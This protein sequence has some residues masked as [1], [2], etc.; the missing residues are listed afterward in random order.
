MA[1]RAGVRRVVVVAVVTG[2]A[3]VG[4]HRVRSVQRVIV[5]VDG[6]TGRFPAGGGMAGRTIGGYPQGA[7]V[8]IV[9][10]VVIGRMAAGAGIRCVVVVAVVANIAVVRDGGVRSGQRVKTI[11]VHGRWHPC[12]FAVAGSAV[13]RELLCNVVG[14]G[15][16]VVIGRMASR[17]GV[18]RVVVVAV[19]TGSAVVGNH[20][21]R[22]VQ[23]VIVVVDGK[24]GRFP[25]GGGMAGRTIGGYPQGA[26]VGIVCLVVIGRMAAGAGIRCVVVVAVV[27]NIAVV[28]D[29]GVRSGQRVK[30]IVV[31]GRRHPCRFAVA[32][33]A[34]RREL[35]CNVVWIG[36]LVVVGRM[37]TCTGIRRVVVVA[38]VAGGAFVGD[39]RMCAVQRVVVVVDGKTG[40]FPAN[41][42]MAGRTIGGYPQG[43]V[44]WIGRLVV[45]GCMAARTGVRRVGIVAVVA[46]I[47]IA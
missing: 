19:V 33:G 14:I 11:V 47:A 8:G 5:V 46:S 13:R 15:R 25:A 38:V 10:L 3:V 12:R 17:A 26:V 44:V 45:I 36:R 24:T 30:T 39:H 1:S 27:A 4:N 35:L 41:I 22:S 29:G 2:S 42:R 20:R 32:G 43:A 7:V 21:V 18:R 37:A 6:K 16:L 23:R 34:V 28:R 9:C 31:H 40:R